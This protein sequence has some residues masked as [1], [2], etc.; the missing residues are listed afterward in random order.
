VI[1]SAFFRTLRPV[2]SSSGPINVNVNL[3]GQS[4]STGT[5]APSVDSVDTFLYYSGIMGPL[6]PPQ[7]WYADD[8]PVWYKPADPFPTIA[9][10]ASCSGASPDNK[11][12]AYGETNSPYN[13]VM[14]ITDWT[15]VTTGITLH[16]QPFSIDF[17]RDSLQMGVIIGTSPDVVIFNTGT[18]TTK[19]SFTTSGT[20]AAKGQ[21]HPSADRFV[22]AHDASPWLTTYNTNDFSAA[23][24]PAIA[25]AIEYATLKFSPSGTYL[26]VG[27]TASPYLAVYDTSDWSRIT[28][29]ATIVDTVLGIGWTD[30]ESQLIIGGGFSGDSMA[31][32]DT[33]TWDFTSDPV[34]QPPSI[35]VVNDV[36]SS[37]GDEFTVMASA[38]ALTDNAIAVYRNKDW[39]TV[40]HPILGLNDPSFNI[41]LYGGRLPRNHSETLTGLSMTTGTTAPTVQISNQSVNVN[42]TGQSITSSP[43]LISVDI[44]GAAVWD[45]TKKTAGVTLN[46]SKIAEING[47]DYDRVLST[48]PKNSGKWYAEFVVN[49]D[50]DPSV[51]GVGIVSNATI[52]NTND[53]RDEN[54]CTLQGDGIAWKGHTSSATALSPVDDDIVM[55]AFDID[56]GKL[57]FGLNGSWSNSGNPATGTTPTLTGFTGTSW[58]IWFVGEAD[59]TTKLCTYAS[60][61]G[62]FTYTKP[63]GYSAL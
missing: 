3:T 15:E 28:L 43:G 59:P 12:F 30:D 8:T 16:G 27:L 14:D 32:I 53:W 23:S 58:N 52:D 34:T 38:T 49:G 35:T 22:I 48:K 5:T 7:V 29:T 2:S 36:V 18:W 33:D 25:Q 61:D 39:S 4:I 63:S 62:E 54:C 17:S 31:I 51:L 40:E 11:Y 50:G 47:S 1:P 41:F 21:Y 26:A 42:L 19:A 6:N 60:T 56:A 45:P 10:S 20:S 24:G 37:T 44:P 13:V 9:G 46:T 57:W 55:I